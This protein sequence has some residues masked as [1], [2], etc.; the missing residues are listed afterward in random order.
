MTTFR[1]PATRWAWPTLLFIPAVMLF[2]R[3]VA[4]QD[5]EAMAKWTSYQIV[6]YKFVGEFSGETI[7]LKGSGTSVITS[8]SARA[9]DRIEIEFD[10]DQQ[11][12]N[13]VGKPVIRNFPT[14]L[15]AIVPS[16][17]AECPAPKVDG[18]LE[19]ATGLSVKVDE[20]LRMSGVVSLEARRDQPG[21]SY[22]SYTTALAG[23]GKSVCGEVWEAATP[24]SETLL[25][26]LTAVPGMFLAMLPP[27]RTD[28]RLTADKKSF[29][30][31]PG[32]AG[33]PS[34]GWTWTVTPT[35]V[36]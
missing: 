36:K 21:G 2:A 7:V 10:W 5:F 3:D 1:V 31:P 18:A 6:H 9:T 19:V 26:S 17:L 14:R 12:F 20:T 11:E 4:A 28:L 30:V 15:V 32:E 16:E 13:L 34:H 27:D 8:I 23:T 25:I 22:A 29:I 24:R 35:G 33:T